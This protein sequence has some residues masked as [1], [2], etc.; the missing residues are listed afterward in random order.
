M[1]T[2]ARTPIIP[3]TTASSTIEKPLLLSFLKDFNDM[4][5]S[6]LLKGSDLDLS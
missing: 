2:A 3:V 1:A 4:T 6:I 5:A